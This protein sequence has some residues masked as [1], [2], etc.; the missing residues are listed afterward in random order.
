MGGNPLTLQVAERALAKLDAQ[1]E[2][3]KGAAHPRFAIYHDGILV[4]ATGLRHSSNRDI[5][6]PHVKHD[7]RVSTQFVLDLAR[8]P[9]SKMDW[10]VAVGILRPDESPAAPP[11]Q[12]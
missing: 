9:K 8:C 12:S 5:P 3:P 1:D 11:D 7:L 4:A 6:V 10:L 2:T